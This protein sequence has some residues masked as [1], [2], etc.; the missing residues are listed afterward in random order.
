MIVGFKMEIHPNG[1][2]QEILRE[3]C[4]TYHNM[5]NFLVAKYKDNL[6]VVSK[7]GIK[8]FDTNDLINEFGSAI[9]KRVVLG[10]IK[11]YSRAVQ[12]AYNKVVNRPKFHK[13]NPNKQSFYIASMTYSVTNGRAVI[14]SLG[15][16]RENMSYRIPLDIE[17]LNKYNIK[18]IIEP[19]FTFYKGKWYIS[20]SYKK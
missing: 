20:G 16:G 5:W 17:Y 19:R 18:E 15:R 9:P 4:K 14:P 8:D 6:P 13:Y 11:E 3:Y 7:Y 1:F 12:M 10:V 2:Q